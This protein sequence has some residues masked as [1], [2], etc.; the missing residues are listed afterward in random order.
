MVRQ[1]RAGGVRFLTREPRPNARNLMPSA[2]LPKHVNFWTFLLMQFR[3]DKESKPMR[4]LTI[5]TAYST[6]GAAKVAYTLHQYMLRQ[7]GIYSVFLS[8]R[9]DM[10]SS[11]NII[12]LR[13]H[14]LY[15]YANAIAY[16]LVA[17]EG[18]FYKRRLA[19]IL[20][21]LIPHI[22]I[23]HMHNIHGYYIDDAVF[24][25]LENMPV[26]WTLHD[27]WIATGRCTFPVDCKEVMNRCTRC[28]NILT[29][30]PKTWLLHN[31]NK[32]YEMR[33]ELLKMFKNLT[34]VV[35]SHAFQTCLANYHIKHRKVKVIYNG[36]NAKVFRPPNS[37]F[38][39]Q[40]IM[41]KLSVPDD[42]LPIVCFI[43][44]RIYE[45]RKGFSILNTSLNNL[46]R[47]I[48]LLI[49]G[50][51]KHCLDQFQDN[52][53]INMM[54]C[55]Y[56]DDPN[57]L[58]DYLRVA[59]VV[60]NPSQEETFGLTSIEALS[61]GARPVVFKLPIFQ[62]VL[63]EWA[64]FSQEKNSESLREAILSSLENPFSFHEKQEAYDYVRSYFSLEKMCDN[65]M[66][67]YRRAIG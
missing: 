42:G 20:K 51:S 16:R 35:P 11:Q 47:A 62:E 45:Q 12:T 8:G 56:I 39:R 33:R 4:V 3:S 52:R 59:D 31:F 34:L 49:I 26:V 25:I 14:Y 36:I 17:K 48:R 19:R 23:V 29:R 40:E 53:N 32:T 43:A 15:E 54:S 18:L 24:N 57:I 21:D 6:G 44:R 10:V 5:N 67:L 46:G 64:I 55:G 13:Q 7:D 37:I 58:A 61:C 1:N 66:A 41:N 60:V 30:Y 50:E 63:G 27:F 2:R 65:Y 22:D 28:S 9:G 38:E